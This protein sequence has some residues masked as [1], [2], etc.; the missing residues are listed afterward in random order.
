MRALAAALLFVVSYAAFGV[1]APGRQVVAREACT[2]VLDPASGALQAA[3]DA[4]NPGDTICLRRGI[5]DTGKPFGTAA[6]TTYV[7]RSGRNTAYITLRGFENERPVIHGSF[8]ITASFWKIYGLV[9]EGPLNQDASTRSARRDNLVEIID[10]SNLVF[11]ANEVKGSDYHAGIYLKHANAISISDCDIHQNG[12]FGMEKDPE[13][14][15]K[16]INVDHGIYWGSSVG[17]G[18]VIANNRIYSNRGYGLHLYPHASHISVV[19]NEI[20][21]NGNSGVIIAG[22]S[23]GIEVV[24]NTVVRNGSN[25]QI[26]VRSGNSNVV[27]NN[28]TF[29]DENGISGIENRTRS[30]VASNILLGA[31]EAERR[32]TAARVPK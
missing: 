32:L 6:D 18:N 16:T 12:R 23:D 27:R 11:R 26:R 19:N 14:G 31:E 24:G 29:A 3:L 7:R 28:S 2:V 13:T 4:A 25:A 1:R 22:D 15:A 30:T 5:Y 10:S 9:F 8:R 21:D 17:E 20:F